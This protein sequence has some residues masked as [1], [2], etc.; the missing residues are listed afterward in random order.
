MTIKTNQST[1]SEQKDV[2]YRAMARS[3]AKEKGVTFRTAARLIQKQYGEEA[4]TAFKGPP[5]PL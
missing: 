5:L 4:R 1:K 2:D 3:L